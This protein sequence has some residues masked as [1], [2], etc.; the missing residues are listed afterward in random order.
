MNYI[1]QQRAMSGTLHDPA[2]LPLVPIA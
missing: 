2:A 1:I